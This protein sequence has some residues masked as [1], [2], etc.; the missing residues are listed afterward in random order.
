MCIAL[1]ELLQLILYSDA[2]KLAWLQSFVAQSE[3][4]LPPIVKMLSA[5]DADVRCSA[6]WA[7]SHLVNDARPA[8]CES[9]MAALPW[10]HFSTL[11]QDA[12]STVQVG[13]C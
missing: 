6:M 8:V 9:V 1:E 7:L 11:L 13:F 2:D 5:A 4:G 10:D 12:D 3:H